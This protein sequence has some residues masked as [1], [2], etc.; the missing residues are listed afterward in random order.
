MALVVGN[1]QETNLLNLL[2]KQNNQFIRLYTNDY[3]PDNTSV[4]ASFTE[5]TTHG[6]QQ[7]EIITTDW[8]IT[9]TASGSTAQNLTQTWTFTEEPQISVYGYFLV[10]TISGDLVYAERFPS[11]Q[12][13]VNQDDQ[14]VITPKITIE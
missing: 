8:T 9:N 3:T 6:Y 12:I 10:D 13:I 4:A 14:I 7:K 5:M 11:A 1:V 2:L